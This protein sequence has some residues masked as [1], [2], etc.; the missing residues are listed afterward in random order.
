[1]PS[2]L[3][4]AKYL[5]LDENE[6]ENTTPLCP[7]SVVISFFYSKLQIFTVSSSLPRA[8]YLPSGENAIDL[9]DP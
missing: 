5:P 7:F 3:P 8:I 2:S 1:M 6:T 4:E 9:T